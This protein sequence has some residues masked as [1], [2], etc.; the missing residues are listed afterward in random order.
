[1]HG[2]RRPLIEQEQVQ[3]S[4]MEEGRP[5]HRRHLRR[6]QGRGD[7]VA[8][9]GAEVVVSGRNTERGEATLQKIRDASMTNLRPEQP[10]PEARF[11][12]RVLAVH[13]VS[14]GGGGYY[15]L[16]AAP[17]EAGG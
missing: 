15:H 16:P 1:M 13:A 7:V 17:P 2:V 9:I 12:F 6:W 10:R 3:N 14:G 4:G 5:D 8:A 11:L